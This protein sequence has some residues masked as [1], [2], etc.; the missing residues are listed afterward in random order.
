MTG[1]KRDLLGLSDFAWQRFRQRIEGLSD[2]EYLWEPVPGCW[3]VRRTDDGT[4]RG[5]GGLIFE[6][7]PP[8]T[9]IAWRIAHIIDF[10][11]AERC[12]THLR[13]EP[14]RPVIDEGIPGSARQAIDALERSYAMWRGYLELVDA[15][16]LDE[17]LGPIAG[18]YADETRLGFVLHIIDELIHH[19]AEVAV[20]RDL[21]RAQTP[22]DS[23]VAA[24]LNG[25]RDAVDAADVERL[26]KEEPDL[27]RRAAETGRWHALPVLVELGFPVDG[28]NGRNA[29]HHAAGAGRLDS[30]RLL[31]D[32]GADVDARDPTYDST[33]LGW[34]EYMRRKETA[35]YLRPLTKA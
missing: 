24:L 20:L 21:Y 9:T 28:P 25:D 30:V 33:P 16:V 35:D 23:A 10:L 26:L 27:M 11:A 18:I 17:K 2:E 7:T 19:T 14:K 15:E 12:A 6:E 4:Y 5:D 22:E 1:I 32:R 29:L 8:F 34:A 3:S 13:L 31:I